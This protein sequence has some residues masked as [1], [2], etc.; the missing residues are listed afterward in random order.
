MKTY[1]NKQV[2]ANSFNRKLR[3]VTKIAASHSLSKPF[4]GNMQSHNIYKQQ[5]NM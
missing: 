1:H 5:C 2:Y 4:N 3:R